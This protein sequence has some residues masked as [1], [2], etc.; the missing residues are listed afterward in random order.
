MNKIKKAVLVI[1]AILFLLFLIG[2]SQEISEEK[3]STEVSSGVLEKK[4]EVK[5]SSLPYLKYARLLLND[6]K[7]TDKEIEDVVKKKNIGLVFFLCVENIPVKE[8]C[9]LQTG[10]FLK[11]T[12]EEEILTSKY[13]NCYL[14][15][16]GFLPGEPY[17]ISVLN[18][19]DKSV[20]AEY[21]VFPNPIKTT[22]PS[23]SQINLALD[24]VVDDIFLITGT[25]F[26]KNEDL[27]ICSQ[28][29]D[30]VLDFPAQCDENGEFNL[31]LNVGVLGKTKGKA[32][33]K[34][35]SPKTKE[36]LELDYKWGIPLE[37]R[38]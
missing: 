5:V 38:F 10:N 2:V 18:K 36:T 9:I 3:K 14:P 19:K 28:S 37:T 8:E 31:S 7:R 13:N 27:L 20:I 29:E 35:Y 24:S 34:V 21:T 16:S 23:G 1:V 32:K 6:N 33:I 12:R 11:E 17:Y 26:I 4:I 22:S 15:T 30:E 25:G